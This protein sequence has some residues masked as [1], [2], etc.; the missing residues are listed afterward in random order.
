MD[1][2]NVAE[3][4][5]LKSMEEFLRYLVR[6]LVDKPDE[7]KVVCKEGD[8]SLILEIQVDKED[9]AKVVGRGGKT[10]QSLRTLAS[11]VSTRLGR[12][13]HVVLVE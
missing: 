3:I 10:I 2:T 13:A 4:A 9:I 6:N 5:A 1:E 11:I 8:R 12:K 7:V